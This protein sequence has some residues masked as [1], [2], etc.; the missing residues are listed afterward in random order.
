[1]NAVNFGGKYFTVMTDADSGALDVYVVTS[2]AKVVKADVP[3]LKAKDIV[4]FGGN[5]FMTNRGVVFTVTNDGRVLINDMRVGVI[6]KRGGNYF[7]DTSNFFYSV[8]DDGLLQTPGLPLSMKVSSI[9]KLG[10]NYFI[11]QQGKFFVVD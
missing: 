3:N 10:S 5:Y 2:D 1:K 4:T 7:T 8:S 6:A 11:D 9:L